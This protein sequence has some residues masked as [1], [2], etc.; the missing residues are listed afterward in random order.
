MKNK[1]DDLKNEALKKIK[2]KIYSY[3]ETIREEYDIMELVEDNIKDIF[4][5]DLNCS[6]CSREEQGQCM[7][8]FKKA[9][10]YFLRKLYLDET[11]LMEFSQNI[12]EMIEL[13]EETRNILE[14]DKTKR[15]KDSKDKYKNRFEEARKKH[16]KDEIPS[17]YI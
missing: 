14:R 2:E 3:S 12:L 10:L 9:N 1:N 13:V 17:F 11:K 5:C 4:N 15:L 8:S 16:Q 7:Q 6:T